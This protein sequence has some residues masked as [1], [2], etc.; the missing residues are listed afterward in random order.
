MFFKFIKINIFLLLLSTLCN[1][2]VINDIIVNNNNRISKETIITYGNIKIGNDYTQSELNT[3]LKNLYETDFFKDLSFE[4]ENDVLIINV[5][6]NKIIQEVV[7]NG[8][9]KNSLKEMIKKNL[10]MRDKSTFIE[11]KG[12]KDIALIKNGLGTAAD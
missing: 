12:K 4:I 8:V 2:E 9:K 10:S 5:T 1:A 6:E 7:I 11:T 3:V